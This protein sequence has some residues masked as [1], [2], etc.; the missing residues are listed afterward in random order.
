[1]SLVLQEDY[2]YEGLAYIWAGCALG[3]VLFHLLAERLLHCVFGYEVRHGGGVC[4]GCVVLKGVK[5]S[6]CQMDF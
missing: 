3:L 2:K 5:C 1:M 6:R 4:S